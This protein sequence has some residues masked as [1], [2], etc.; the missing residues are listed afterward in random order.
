MLK[1]SQKLEYA[2][3]AMIELSLRRPEGTLVPAR[4]IARAQQIPVRFLEQQLGALHKAGLV[5]SF[6][7][8]GG[9]CRLA[10]DPAQITVAEIADAIEGQLYPM[11]CLEP[12]DHTCFADS[13]CGLQGFWGDVARAIEGVFQ[14]TTVAELVERHR[15]TAG[16]TVFTSEQ[17]LSRL[18]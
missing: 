8:A 7:G 9:G 12:T 16:P 3:R 11:F 5:E 14:R 1:I 17:L 18:N 2:M 10:R 4:E 13:R 6:R 15:Q